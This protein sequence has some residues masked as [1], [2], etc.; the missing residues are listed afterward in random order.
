MDSDSSSEIER[1]MSPFEIAKVV[2]P[3]MND[4][5]QHYA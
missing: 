1:N 3:M 5:E 4:S 2:N